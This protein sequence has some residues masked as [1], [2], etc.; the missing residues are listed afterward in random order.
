[1]P[2]PNSIVGPILR[3]IKILT[4]ATVV[5]YVILLLVGGAALMTASRNQGALCELRSDLDRRITLSENLLN[6]HPNGIAGLTPLE[7]RTSIA[8]QR[9]TVVALGGLNCD[10]PFPLSLVF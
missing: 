2:D 3:Q 4:T 5:L 9:R 8:N 6:R 1:V 7:V 10:Q